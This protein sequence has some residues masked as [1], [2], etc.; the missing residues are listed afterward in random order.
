MFRAEYF[1][2]LKIEQPERYRE[3]CRNIGG[4]SQVVSAAWKEL[5][6]EAKNYYHA[7]ARENK[8]SVTNGPLLVI[9]I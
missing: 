6:P 3:I 4:F 9:P 8:E 2:H 5:A 7:I 1:K